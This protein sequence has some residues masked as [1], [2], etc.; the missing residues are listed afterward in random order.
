M[1]SL[2]QNFS[3][4]AE[5][6]ILAASVPIPR[7]I[8]PPSTGILIK[9]DNLSKKLPFCRIQKKNRKGKK[10]TWA[11]DTLSTL[12]LPTS[13]DE[14]II[15][16]SPRALL[17]PPLLLSNSVSTLSILACQDEWERGG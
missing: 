15:Q 8:P 6:E 17:D 13:N 2:E 4:R 9:N 1:G 11:V 3:G 5:E 12:L 7:H 16:P 10:Y 14:E